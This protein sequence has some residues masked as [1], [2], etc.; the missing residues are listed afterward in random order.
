MFVSA[1][2]YQGLMDLNAVL[3][4]QA[5]YRNAFAEK[6][7]FWVIYSDTEKRERLGSATTKKDAW[8]K[9]YHNVCKIGSEK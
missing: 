1:G 8:V 5:K 2:S 6:S 9:A 3:W 7:D 4:V